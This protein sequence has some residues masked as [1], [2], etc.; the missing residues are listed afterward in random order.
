MTRAEDR[1]ATYVMEMEP[2]DVEEVVGV[3]LDSFQG[4]F[5]SFLGS[6]FLRLYYRS[7]LDFD[8]IALVA[9]SGGRV[10][11]FVVG[12]DAEAGFYRRLLTTR[13]HRFAWASLPALWRKPAI[14]GRLFRALLK[15]SARATDGT[16]TANLT[17]LAVLS[18]AQGSGIGKALVTR[19]ISVA[20]ARG[21]RRV[22]LE[23]DALENEEVIRFYFSLGF[24]EH[25]DYL[26]PEGRR[27]IELWWEPSSGSPPTSAECRS[28]DSD[29]T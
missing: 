24:S 12:I 25:H 3:H 8:Q 28:R 22:I 18:T 2:R 27:M 26:T 13:A 7:I 21:F 29:R 20:R 10:L 4:F 9:T 19:F 16:S 11:G 6:D 5:L 14:V 15:R 1:D 17:S 23:T